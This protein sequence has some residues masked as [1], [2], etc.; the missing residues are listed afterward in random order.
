M[1]R[2]RRIASYHQGLPNFCYLD[3]C[4]LLTIS[5]KIAAETIGIV[6]SIVLGVGAWRVIEEHKTL[7]YN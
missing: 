6:A 4:I 7:A 3:S 2:P 5:A 1:V